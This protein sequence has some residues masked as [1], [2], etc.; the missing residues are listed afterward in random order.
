MITKDKRALRQLA[1]CF[2]ICGETLYRHSDDGVLLLCLD[3]DSVVRVMREVHVGVHGP[4]MG[5]HM[6]ARKIKRTSYF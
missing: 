5:G 6:L 1:T 4:H 3:K 2:V